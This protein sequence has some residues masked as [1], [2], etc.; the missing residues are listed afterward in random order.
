MKARYVAIMTLCIAGLAGCAADG[1]YGGGMGAYGKTLGGGALGGAAGGLIGSAAGNSAAAT[2]AG[3]LLGTAAGAYMGNQLDQED[4][5]RNANNAHY[6][7]LEQG[8]YNNNTRYNNNSTSN[9]S[10]YKSYDRNNRP[11][12]ICPDR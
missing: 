1:G 2:A 5:R 4:Q 9:S 3:A 6:Q 7:R 12:T 10:C 8:S 11:V